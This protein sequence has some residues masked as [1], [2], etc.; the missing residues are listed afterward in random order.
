MI[1]MLLTFPELATPF[2]SV[3]NNKTQHAA[4]DPTNLTSGIP[5]PLEMSG[6]SFRTELLKYCSAE[7]MIV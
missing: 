6:F 7:L 1:S 4:K 2:Q 5:I 3:K